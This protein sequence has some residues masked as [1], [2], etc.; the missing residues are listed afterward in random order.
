[1]KWVVAL[2][3][4]TA[5]CVI[6]TLNDEDISRNRCLDRPS[7]MGGSSLPI[8]QSKRKLFGSSCVT[9]RRK[10]SRFVVVHSEYAPRCEGEVPLH[11]RGAVI[12]DRPDEY[13]SAQTLCSARRYG[14]HPM[15]NLGGRC[16]FQILDGSPA[17]N[18]FDFD[19]L[20]PRDTLA[21]DELLYD[22]FLDLH[23]TTWCELHCFCD[24]RDQV[25][26][27]PKR[28]YSHKN[29]SQGGLPQDLK[30]GLFNSAE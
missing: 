17:S 4:M 9:N 5:T 27:E 28:R 30:N 22:A 8:N 1:M 23:Y 29:P 2:L 10:R 26:K 14:G 18:E 3:W 20:T 21:R 15:G 16:V 12:N 19:A 25:V 7:G 24:G 13:K 11:I 6:G